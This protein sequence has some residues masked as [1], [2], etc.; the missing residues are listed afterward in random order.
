MK[1][2]QDDIN[3]IRDFHVIEKRI[4]ALDRDPKFV[5]DPEAQDRKR[6]RLQA[7]LA[8]LGGIDA[9][10]KASLS[11]ERQFSFNSAHWVL[12]ELFD[13]REQ[14]VEELLC[15]GIKP[16]CTL[17]DV[18][19]IKNKYDPENEP[20]VRHLTSFFML[21][22][23][24]IDLNPQDKHVIKINFLDFAR[25]QLPGSFSIVVLSLCIN[26]EGNPT[27]RGEM[28]RMAA[29]LLP[30]GG[31]C[32]VLLPAPC[33][34]NSRYMNLNL[35]LKTLRVVG[36][37]LAKH[38]VNKQPSHKTSRKLFYAVA[39]KRI[40]LAQPH[41]AIKRT[42]C[43]GGKHRNNFCI[44]VKAQVP[45]KPKTPRPAHQR[46]S[47]SARRNLRAKNAK[48]RRRG[49][50][51]QSASNATRS[52]QSGRQNDVGD[53]RKK[54]KKNRWRKRKSRAP[55]SANAAMSFPHCHNHYKRS[56]SHHNKR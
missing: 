35:F 14:I 49:E 1:R 23:T 33:V 53:H 26:F 42:L 55:T 11:G 39:R 34:E 38:P 36:L 30:E 7:E 8:K 3:L 13:R 5:G 6:T 32:F 18:G 28:L 41:T 48:R 21:Q 37:E 52:V 43:R 25:E 51:Q 12:D 19:A 56:K 31:F 9:Y 46:M 27:K 17:L 4:A 22:T 16:A 54:N 45:S 29:H 40:A 20:R 15:K 2:S 47:K 24:S 44:I 50:D 10:Q